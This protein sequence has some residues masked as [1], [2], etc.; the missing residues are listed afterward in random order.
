MPDEGQSTPAAER[1]ASI[2]RSAEHPP[3]QR[4]TH[5]LVFVWHGASG[6]KHERTWQFATD[7][8]DDIWVALPRPKEVVTIRRLGSE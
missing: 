6:A 7:D 8:P 2:Q 1:S 3:V 5:E 4:M